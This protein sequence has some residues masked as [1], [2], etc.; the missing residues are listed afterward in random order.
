MDTKSELK[1]TSVRNWQCST[2]SI[3][4][5]QSILLNVTHEISWSGTILY[6]QYTCRRQIQRV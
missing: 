1:I 4:K 5:A 3:C 6:L 2:W